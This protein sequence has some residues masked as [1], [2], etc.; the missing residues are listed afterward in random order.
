MEEVVFYSSFPPIL[1]IHS[2]P[3]AFL[4]LHALLLPLL[5]SHSPRLSSPPSSLPTS[6]P[7]ILS[8]SPLTSPFLLPTPPLTSS[9]PPLPLPSS[10]LL[11]I[12]ITATGRGTGT[13]RLSSP[14]TLWKT[15]TLRN[16]TYSTAQCGVIHYSVVQ[17][18]VIHD[19]TVRTVH[20]STV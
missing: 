12:N 8:P 4:F 15:G 3:F 13:Q 14:G 17:C 18:S 1:H 11:F 5:L 20:C 2:L 10:P 16:S 9:F 7:P 6:P 19:S